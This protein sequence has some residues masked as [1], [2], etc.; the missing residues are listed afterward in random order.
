MSSEERVLESVKRAAAF[1]VLGIGLV[2]Y[3]LASGAII[4]FGFVTLSHA[5]A[6]H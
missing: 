6:G 3:V 5:V 4:Y 1:V 2:G